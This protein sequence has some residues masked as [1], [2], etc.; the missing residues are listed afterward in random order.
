MKKH[1]FANLSLKEVKNFIETHNNVAF[2]VLNKNGTKVNA[3][4]VLPKSVKLSIKKN[5]KTLIVDYYNIN[6]Y[7]NDIE[8][9][10]YSTPAIITLKRTDL[11]IGC[12]GSKDEDDFERFK[13]GF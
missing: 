8:I 3:G 5:G 13:I 10:D 1:C 6:S 2:G 11:Y 4:P 12:V 9:I 7:G